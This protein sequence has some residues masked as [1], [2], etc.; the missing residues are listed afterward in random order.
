MN[1][2]TVG[3]VEEL[4][5]REGVKQILVGPYEKHTITVEGPCIILVIED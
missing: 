2:P 5:T 1:N 3:L 4:L